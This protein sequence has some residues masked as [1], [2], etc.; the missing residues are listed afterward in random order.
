MNTYE[1]LRSAIRHSQSCCHA[2]AP[3]DCGAQAA[4]DAL[5]IMS[6]T[7]KL[8]E[9][10]TPAARMREKIAAKLAP[11]GGADVK[12][13]V[14]RE[15]DEGHRTS[16]DVNVYVKNGSLETSLVDFKGYGNSELA[17]LENIARYIGVAP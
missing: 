16:V 9:A 17:C 5:A 4:F 10:E 8:G 12:I 13:D 11:L 14:G 15:R 2:V 6:A 3:C 1:A 7:G